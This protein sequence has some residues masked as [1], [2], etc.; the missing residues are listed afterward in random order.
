MYEQVV[1]KIHEEIVCGVAR[2]GVV[3]PTLASKYLSIN[4]QMTQ[5]SSLSSPATACL[6][7]SEIC[8][9]AQMQSMIGM[10]STFFN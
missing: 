3:V 5:V 7:N 1:D 4:T 9:S 10:L 2:E 8:G 6:I